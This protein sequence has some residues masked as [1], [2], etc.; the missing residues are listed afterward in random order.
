MD[1]GLW[2]LLTHGPGLGAGDERLGNRAG[3][4]LERRVSRAAI[5]G[6]EAGPQ[7]QDGEARAHWGAARQ[8]IEAGPVGG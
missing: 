3:G 4:A 7:E 2:S 8:P 6:E 1:F 5:D